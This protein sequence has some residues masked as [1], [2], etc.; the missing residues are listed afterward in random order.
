MGNVQKRNR[1]VLSNSSSSNF[2]F[3]SGFGF[4]ALVAHH[5]AD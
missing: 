5:V 4:P 3:V 1:A 2:G